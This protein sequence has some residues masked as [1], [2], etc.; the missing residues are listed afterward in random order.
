MATEFALEQ[1]I[2]LLDG[3]VLEIFHSGTEE[4]T[5]YHVSYLRI[6]ATPHRDGVKVRLG[7]AYG[8]DDITGGRRWTMSAEK[9]AEFQVFIADAI[10]ARDNGP[11]A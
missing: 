5:R 2:I 8:K 1:E 4:S 3:R 11:A 9:F 6:N 10:T 7:R